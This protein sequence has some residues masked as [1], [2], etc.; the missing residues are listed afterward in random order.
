MT[1]ARSTHDGETVQIAYPSVLAPGLPAFTMD[2]PLGWHVGEFPG[3]LIAAAAPEV[4]GQFRPN[5]VVTGRRV[6]DSMPLTEAADDAIAELRGIY[7]DVVTSDRQVTND[8]G[9]ELLQ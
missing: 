9:A 4:E 5:L 8:E 3:A 1:D 6:P 7:G 2:A